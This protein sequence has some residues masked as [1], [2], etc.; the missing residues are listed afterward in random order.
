MKEKLLSY[1]RILTEDIGVRSVV[2][3][4]ENLKKTEEYLIKVLKEYKGILRRQP[5]TYK[6]VEVANL[7]YDITPETPPKIKSPLIIGAHYD[8][9]VGTVGADDNASS[10]AALLMLAEYFE[11]HP[12]PIN[13]RLLFFTLE[14]PPVWNS[15][16]MG[17]RVYV[18]AMKKHNEKIL[19]AIIMDGVA[20]T[21]EK[22][23]YPMALKMLNFPTEGNFI[24]ILPNSAS[25]NFAKQ[26]IKGFKDNPLLPYVDFAIMGKGEL[27]PETRLSDHSSFWDAGYNALL[28]TDT[29][30]LRNPTYHTPADTL[31]TLDINFLEQV[32]RG[33][34][35]TIEGWSAEEK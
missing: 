17:S 35:N 1:L 4:P 21:S 2:I 8:T 23:K 28:L 7:I 31:D 22:Q 6:R 25:K 30:L 18:K 13:L 11:T 19:G 26:V 14:E 24:A 10:I 29:S 5:Y 34:I 12:T 15:P 16:Y 33:L 20:Y 27:I 32:V 9:V 3:T